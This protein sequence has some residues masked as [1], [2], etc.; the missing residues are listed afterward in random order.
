LPAGSQWIGFINPAGIMKFAQII[1]KTAAPQI[2][3]KVPNFPETQPLGFAVR[4]DSGIIDTEFVVPADTLRG[5][6][7]YVQQVQ[8]GAGSAR[9]N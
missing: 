5:I 8:S 2:A 3:A 7:E 6:G 1:M 4:A 9:P